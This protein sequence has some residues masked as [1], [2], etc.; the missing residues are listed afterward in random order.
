MRIRLT[1]AVVAVALAACSTGGTPSPA[2][3]PSPATSLSPA[4]SPSSIP[5]ESPT[6]STAVIPVKVT[7]DG[8]TCRYLGPEVFPE[9]TI[10][11]FEYAPT[12]SQADTT[13]LVVFG[14]TEGMPA[15]VLDHSVTQASQAPAWVVQLH[16]GLQPGPGDMLYTMRYADA[17]EVA[18]LVS[19]GTSA[20][21]PA[22]PPAT[23]D[24]L[25][26]AALLW[27]MPS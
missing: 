15:D 17:N 7:F 8:T 25:Y 1:A 26:P 21:E 2:A 19:C 4:P 12:A 16:L 24:T 9:G 27:A 13:G 18:V 5:S 11:K 3:S 14:V 22:V 6:A 10:V 20:D 23:D